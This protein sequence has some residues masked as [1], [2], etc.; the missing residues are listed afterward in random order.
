MSQQSESINE[1]AAALSKAQGEM[2]NASKDEKGSFGSFASLASVRDTITPPL[3]KYDLSLVQTFDADQFGDY[4]VTTLLHKSGQWIRGRMRLQLEKP[5]MQGLGSATSYSRRYSESA[6]VNLAQEDDDAQQSERDSLG[7]KKAA[8]SASSK[9]AHPVSNPAGGRGTPISEPQIKRFWGLAKTHDWTIEEIKDLLARYHY[10][11]APQIGWKDYQTMCD[12]LQK[13]KV[14]SSK[15]P[16]P[17]TDS[18][19]QEIP[20]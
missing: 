7:G 11:S 20:F 19:F 18:D 15:E 2:P 3:S 10:Q 1:L 12:E 14:S 6:M 13:K 5:T 16:P 4:L 9:S 8:P 17:H